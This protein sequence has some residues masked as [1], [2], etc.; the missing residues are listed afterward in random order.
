MLRADAAQLQLIGDLLQAAL[1]VLARLHQVFHIVD[2]G[3]VQAQIL[4]EVALL[5]RQILVGQQLQ[6]IAEIVARVKAQPPH[7]VHQDDARRHQQLGKV[8][9]IDA[10]LLV[11]FELDAGVL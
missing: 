5:R 1:Q 11:L 3:K 6:Q 2:G 9:A 7:V 10:L 8:Q 4:E